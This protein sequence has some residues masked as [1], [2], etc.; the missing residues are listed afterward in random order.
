MILKNSS[1]LFIRLDIDAAAHEVSTGI[2]VVKIVIIKKIL[3][4]RKRIYWA[5]CHSA[6]HMCRNITG[7]RAGK[8]GPE[9]MK[10]F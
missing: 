1:P 5:Q 2:S 3:V 6:E 8:K 7:L 9:L 10:E 4:H